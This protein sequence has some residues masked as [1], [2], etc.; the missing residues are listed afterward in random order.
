VLERII[1][2]GH[3]VGNHTYSHLKGWYTPNRQYYE[4][5]ELASQFVHSGLYRPAYGLITPAQAR[6]LQ[7]RFHIVLWDVM[8]YDFDP[9]VSKEK[10]LSNVTRY[11]RAGSVV[12]FHDSVKAS[13]NLLF[14][15]PRVLEYFGGKGFT[16]EAIDR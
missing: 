6:Y 1:G 14:A 15:L 10:C 16:F 11:A 3:A 4:D 5:I 13:A 2:A 12:V 8:S 7:H 9:A